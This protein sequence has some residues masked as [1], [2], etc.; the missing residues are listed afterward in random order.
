METISFVRGIHRSPQRPVTRSFDVFFYLRL[1]KRLC[2]QSRRRW[3]ET[4]SRSLWRHCDAI[5]LYTTMVSAVDCQNIGKWFN[6]MFDYN[7]GNSITD[8]RNDIY[9]CQEYSIFTEFEN[10][11]LCWIKYS[12]YGTSNTCTQ[13]TDK[14]TDNHI[15]SIYFEQ[16]LHLVLILKKQ[17]VFSMSQIGVN[18]MIANNSQ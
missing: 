3:F 13:D 4:S 2:K 16:T 6:V 17:W 15:H 11:Q 1:N 10:Q 14:I 18:N 9:Q 5:E 8:K 7:F 12:W